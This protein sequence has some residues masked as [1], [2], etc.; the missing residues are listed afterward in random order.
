MT[1][2]KKGLL[3]KVKEVMSKE[4]VEDVVEEE[5]KE[6]Y[7]DELGNEIDIEHH[8]EFGIDNKGED[9]EGEVDE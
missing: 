3:S 4:P 5:S 2:K 8:E 6:V 9:E 1:K 7:L